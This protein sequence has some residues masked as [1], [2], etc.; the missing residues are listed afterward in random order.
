[1]DKSQHR[2]TKPRF[3]YLKTAKTAGTSFVYLLEQY[4]DNVAIIDWVDD[5]PETLEQVSHYDVICLTNPAPTNVFK[6][7][8]PELFNTLTKVCIIRDPMDRVIS[9]YNYCR[10]K[11]KIPIYKDLRAKPSLLKVLRNPPQGGLCESRK[12]YVADFVHFTLQQ[13]DALTYTLSKFIN[14]K[15]LMVINFHRFNDEVA[16]FFWKKAGRRVDIPHKNPSQR[17][18]KH[19][20]DEEKAIA[21]SMFSDDIKLF[22]WVNNKAIQ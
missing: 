6:H 12:T 10:F 18:V 1:M 8:F 7:R 11:S 13:I 3:I 16:N 17:I 5:V 15:T 19:L 20:S 9:S 2:V 4:F 14:D 22:E 21:K